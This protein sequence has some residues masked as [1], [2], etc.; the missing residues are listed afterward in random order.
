MM[1][2]V[3]LADYGWTEALAEALDALPAGLGPARVLA[4]SSGIYRLRAHEGE[5]EA[6]V[7]GRLKHESASAAELPAVGDWV[8]YRAS[9]GGGARIEHVLPRATR[10]SRK[11]PGK[12]TAEQV[13]AANVD[14]VLVVMGLDED[15]SLR[16]AERLL[17]TVREGGAAPVFVLSKADL[18]DDPVE[19][20]AAVEA[21][22]PGVPVLAANIR[23]GSGIE[24]IRA[25][26]AD[27]ETAALIGSSGA[28]KSTLINR[29]LG[30]AVQ[31]TGA[32]RATDGTGKHTTTHRELFL[33]PGG[34]MVIDN[35]GIRE[36][37]LWADPEDLERT[38]EDVA[39]V[40]QGCRY[41]DC[42]HGGEPGCAVRGAVEAGA[43]SQER[44][45]SYRALQDELQHLARRQDQRLQ[46]DEKQKWKSVH[47]DLRRFYK[48]RKR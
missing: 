15:F 17:A 16:R 34:G 8:A 33:L 24:A 6:S 23:E 19:K 25:H 32:V 47:K 13:V 41:R 31:K 2:S 37:Q 35:P 46:R 22:A 9:P 10:L 4:A 30:A 12:R 21:V 5:V 14:T 29:L 39:E 40:A 48:N 20:K 11:V 7:A 1:L 36:V 42:G 38:F 45:D 44:L 3:T 43:L 26:I 18:C 28:G 27:G